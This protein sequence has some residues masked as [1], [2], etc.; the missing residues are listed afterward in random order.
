M[1]TITTQKTTYPL[2]FF[3]GRIAYE[4]SSLVGAFRDGDQVVLKIDEYAYHLSPAKADRIRSINTTLQSL[5]LI[6]EAILPISLP[7]AHN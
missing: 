5:H 7:M 1:A 4:I 6:P 3:R 2:D